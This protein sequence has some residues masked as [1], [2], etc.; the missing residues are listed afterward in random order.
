MMLLPLEVDFGAAEL[1]RQAF[2][3][4]ER[5]GAADIILQIGVQLDLEA[6]VRLRR[7]V[8]FFEFQDQRHEGFRD[9]P[10]AEVAEAAPTIRAGA[11]G[12]GEQRVVHLGGPLV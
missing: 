9:E 3:E 11:E 8:G 2:G 12:V 5:A 7:L 1:F 4:P 10:A 6:G